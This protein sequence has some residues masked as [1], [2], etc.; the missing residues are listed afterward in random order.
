MVAWQHAREANFASVAPLQRLDDTRQMVLHMSQKVKNVLHLT[1][2][3]HLNVSC[4]N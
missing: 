2:I 4:D 1:F 3:Y